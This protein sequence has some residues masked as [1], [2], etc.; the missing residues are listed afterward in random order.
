MH[1]PLWGSGDVLPFRRRATRG[2]PLTWNV[3]AAQSLVNP[4]A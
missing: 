2:M 4:E 3:G 1:A